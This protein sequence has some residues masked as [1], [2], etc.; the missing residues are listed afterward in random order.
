MTYKQVQHYRNMEWNHWGGNSYKELK[1]QQTGIWYVCDQ[2]Q[3]A[4]L[5]NVTSH[6]VTKETR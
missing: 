6:D 1:S 4:K 3:K 5:V 2:E